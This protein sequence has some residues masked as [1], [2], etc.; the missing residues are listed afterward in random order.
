MGHP[1]MVGGDMEADNV[2]SILPGIGM[3]LNFHP[4]LQ[5]GQGYTLPM[6]TCFFKI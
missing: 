6:N 3:L 5:N 4:V 1:I 2:F